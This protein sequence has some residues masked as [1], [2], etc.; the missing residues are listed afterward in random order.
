MTAN[1]HQKLCLAALLALA[2]PAHAFV[3]PTCPP[4]LGGQVAP[5]R[6]PAVEAIWIRGGERLALISGHLVGRGSPYG[7]GYVTAIHRQS[8]ILRFPSGTRVW[9]LMRAPGVSK[10]WIVSEEPP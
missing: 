3:D 1:W 7:G 6:A 5:A 9:P 4:W 10:R 2:A 8:V